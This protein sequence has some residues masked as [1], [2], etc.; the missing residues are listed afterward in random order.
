MS[1]CVVFYESWQMECCGKIFKT[2]DR[3]KWLVCKCDSLNTP[4]DVGKIEYY[5]EAHDSDWTK[6]ILQKD[7][8]NPMMIWKQVDI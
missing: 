7:S 8:R 2:G 6:Q 1:K 3:I 5:Y 4:V